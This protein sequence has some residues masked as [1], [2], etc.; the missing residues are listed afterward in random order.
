LA[1]EA[2]RAEVRLVG[3]LLIQFSRT[4]AKNRLAVVGTDPIQTTFLA[5]CRDPHTLSVEP[6]AASR[7][8]VRPVTLGG[9]LAVF[10]SSAILVQEAGLAATAAVEVGFVAI[11]NAVGTQ[12]L[13]RV[14]KV[15]VCA[16]VGNR[17]NRPAATGNTEKNQ[18][19]KD[20]AQAGR[21]SGY[22]GVSRIVF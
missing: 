15:G 13:H 17:L 16:R 8:L 20:R 7:H 18:S 10:V 2:G 5:G 9:R 12:L 3:A 22:E 6:V 11:V 4:D 14:L 21:S 19:E 1:E